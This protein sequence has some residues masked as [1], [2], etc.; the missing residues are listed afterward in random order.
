MVIT[1]TEIFSDTELELSSKGLKIH[2]KDTSRPWGG[3]F[4]IE[5]SSLTNFIEEFF[6]GELTKEDLQH[7]TLSPKVL[8]VEPGKRLSWQYHNRRSELWK[9]V[10]GDVDVII[11]KTDQQKPPET[12]ITGDIIR[13]EKGIRHRLIGRDDW[14]IVAEIWQHTD[15]NDPSAEEDIVRIEDDFG[16]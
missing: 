9:I 7:Q 6:P 15:S 3:Y 2:S 10:K 16:R 12:F 14:C 8:L 4:V 11:S 13:L 5:D 1:K